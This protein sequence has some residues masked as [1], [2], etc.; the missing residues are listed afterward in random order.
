MATL[1]LN[2]RKLF[3]SGKLLMQL[4]AHETSILTLLN[5]NKLAV[6]RKD[7]LAAGW[8]NTIV[9]ENSVNMAVKSIRSS[10][11]LKDII[12]TEQGIGYAFNHEAYLLNVISNYFKENADTLEPCQPSTF[13]DINR[14]TNLTSEKFNRFDVASFVISVVFGLCF[15]FSSENEY[16]K[17]FDNI[18]IC[19]LEEKKINDAKQLISSENKSADVVYYYGR[20]NGHKEHT[21]V[22]IK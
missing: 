11:G 5:N 10:T 2:G 1:E 8:P 12:T 3:M 7:L 16:C 15:Y 18:E 14:E 19:S 20:L 4:N 9:S 17:K 21:I 22:E 6:S 13:I